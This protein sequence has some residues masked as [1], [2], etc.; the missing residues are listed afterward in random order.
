MA[1]KRAKPYV[2]PMPEEGFEEVG[3]KFVN[4]SKFTLR[5]T[6][7]LLVCLLVLLLVITLLANRDSIN[8]DNLR[9]LM[10]KIDIGISHQDDVDGTSIEFEYDEDSVVS[11]FK[12]G[13]A[14]LSPSELTIMDNLGT[15]FM[16]AKTGFTSPRLVSGKRYC[17]AYDEG[18][19]HLIVTNS[20][21]VVFDTK[22]SEPIV[23]V[24][25]NDSGYLAVITSGATYKNTLHVY[26]NSFK[27]IFSW[28]STDRYLLRS[29]WSPDSKMLALICYNIKDSANLPE[30]V[31]IKLGVD[32]IYWSAT[33][34]NGL[35]LD[36]SFKSNS[37]I[38]LI[39]N[40]RLL[41]YNVKGKQT[42]SYEYESN[43]L[44]QASL[45]PDDYTVLVLSG[46]KQGNSTVYIVNN[47]GKKVSEYALD[48]SVTQM[49][50]KGERIGLL[51]AQNTYL[52]SV[53]SKKVIWQK[54]ND[55]NVLKVCFGGR[56]C[57][58]DIYNTCAVYN[59]I[60]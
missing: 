28:Q 22:L 8:M 26:D 32:E 31:C 50:V 58:L 14:Y 23:S 11:A 43:F 5:F 6:R 60:N 42:G 52:Y 19:N 20:F 36:L 13:L 18:G 56:N 46:S 51:T 34:E 33:L 53:T 38:A 30:L 49:D 55:G 15:E 3:E 4:R 24:A 29:A 21:A 48:E 57:I 45:V 41:F 44:Q 17:V 37:T 2:E 16:S 35:P 7:Y 10:A 59:E 40:D 39:Q 54:A 27:E 1:K 9:R 25:M 47:R 12:D